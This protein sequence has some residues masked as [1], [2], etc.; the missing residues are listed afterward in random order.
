MRLGGYITGVN[1]SAPAHLGAENTQDLYR[2]ASRNFRVRFLTIDFQ[3]G[4]PEFGADQDRIR[5]RISGTDE[6]EPVSIG[7]RVGAEHAAG[8]DQ[9][10]LSAVEEVI[11]AT[12]CGGQLGCDDGL[13]AIAPFVE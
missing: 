4:A 13:L 2:D 5:S 8:I 7:K 11:R 1:P 3:A 6:R 9:R 10:L 12:D